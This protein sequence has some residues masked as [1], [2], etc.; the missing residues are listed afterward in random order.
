ME[1][2]MVEYSG[3]LIGGPDDGETL[4]TTV[5][6]IIITNTMEMWLDGKEPGKALDIVVTEG[7]YIWMDRYK[8]FE[9]KL[10]SSNRY[11]GDSET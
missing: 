2:V 7:R 1:T 8:H 6:E 5:P 10:V 11:R 4:T 3:R 9:W